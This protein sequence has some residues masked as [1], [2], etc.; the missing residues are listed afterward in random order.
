VTWPRPWFGPEGGAYTGGV[1]AWIWIGAAVWLVLGLEGLWFAATGRKG[2]FGLPR[3]YR[4][5]WPVRVFGLATLLLGGVSAFGLYMASRGINLQFGLFEATVGIFAV[6][7]VVLM[8]WGRP[9][10]TANSL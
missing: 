10:R 9:R 6:V 8:I 1:T 5:G 3:D 7:L 4:E 2:V